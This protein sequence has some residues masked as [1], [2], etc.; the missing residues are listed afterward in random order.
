MRPGALL[1]LT[2]PDIGHWRRPRDIR[3]WDGFSPPAH[4]L[5]FTVRSLARLLA[6][7]PLET[8]HRRFA[9]KPGIKI[10]ARRT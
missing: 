4:C 6:R 8:V 5:Y 2:T 9:W 3:R 7:H 1:Y 10:L